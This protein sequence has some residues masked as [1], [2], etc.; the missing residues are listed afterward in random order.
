MIRKLLLIIN[1]FASISAIGQINCHIFATDT[2]LCYNSTDTLYTN[3]SDTLKYFWPNT[4]D[5]IPVIH[6]QVKDTTTYY[7]TVTNLDGTLTCTDS[8]TVYIYP[9]IYLEFQQLNKGCPDECKSQVRAT[10]SGGFPPY[11]YSWNALVAP[12]DST[13]ALGLCSDDEYGIT[14]RDTICAFDST[15]KVD[16]YHLPDIELSFTPDSLYITNPKAE[17]S[18]EN[19]SADSIMLTNW[20][21]IFPDSTTSNDAIATHVFLVPEFE[22]NSVTDSVKF[23]YTTDDGCTDTLIIEVTIKKFKM[24]IPNV[25]TP[26][27]D[28]TNEKWEIPDLEKYITNEVVVF[29]RWGKKVFEATDYKNNWDGGKLGDGVYFYILRCKGQWKED[30]YRGSVTILGSRH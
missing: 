10:A 7:L 20:E 30:I 22:N 12:N 21:W 27:G 9:R 29:N 16:Y 11:H 15:F 13:L 5:T 6:V 2:L 28:G 26:N 17:F 18:F 23:V 14:I 1:I 3:Y 4:G 24:N 8:I 19:K 25:F